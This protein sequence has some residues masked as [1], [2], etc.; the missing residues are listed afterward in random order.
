DGFV[1]DST[2]ESL[3]V[4]VYN[5]TQPGD[6]TRNVAVMVLS[7]PSLPRGERTL[8]RF[9]ADNDTLANQGATYTAIVQ[10]QLQVMSDRQALGVQLG[11]IQELAL[12][13]DF[14][15]RSPVTQNDVVSGV[16]QITQ[17]NGD[18]LWVDMDCHH[19]RKGDK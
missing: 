14:S 10:R 1:C 4:Q 3:R 13:I 19:Y 11:Q 9:E 18:Q 7:D 12:S 17:V 16:L 6:G 5:R 8:K 15:Y 2:H